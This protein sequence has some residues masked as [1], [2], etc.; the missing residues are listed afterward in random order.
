MPFDFIQC[1]D[2][3]LIDL[4]SNECIKNPVPT[5]SYEA[6]VLHLNTLWS[7]QHLESEPQ[8]V[9]SRVHQNLKTHVPSLPS[10]IWSHAHRWRYA[11]FTSHPTLK[12]ACLFDPHLS[13][14]VCGDWLRGG[15]LT[16]TAQSG[17]ILADHL[18]A[19]HI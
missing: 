18:L 9:I 19:Q 17:A 14:G 8:E 2:D 5:S 10:L 4:M 6:W 3:P 1:T 7:T 11:R 13:L 15:G 12:T 16:Q